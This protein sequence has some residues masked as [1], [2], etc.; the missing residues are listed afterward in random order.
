[1]ANAAPLP[2]RNSSEVPSA[3][4]ARRI[5]RDEA[6][7]EP[8]RRKLDFVSREKRILLVAFSRKRVDVRGEEIDFRRQ[9]GP[10]TGPGGMVVW[11]EREFPDMHRE[12]E[13][14]RALGAGNGHVSRE[15]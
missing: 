7:P 14:A 1:M 11:E 2:P 5:A 9:T 13:G 10:K 12:N 4:E 3:L 15:K 6:S 8:G